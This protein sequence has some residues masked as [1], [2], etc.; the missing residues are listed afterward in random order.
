MPPDYDEIRNILNRD[1]QIIAMTDDFK[2]FKGEAVY[3]GADGY[4]TDSM[5]NNHPL[6]F[7][8]KIVI[9]KEPGPETI[10]SRFE[11]L[12]IRDD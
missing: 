3:V 1:T 4:I 11:I 9:K 7:L 10:S 12:D 5:N 2:V 6:R 8:D